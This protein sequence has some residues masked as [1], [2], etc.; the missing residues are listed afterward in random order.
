MRHLFDIYKAP[1]V[2]QLNSGCDVEI[3]TSLPK[4]DQG[5]QESGASAQTCTIG[6]RGSA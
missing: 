3:K 2:L 1:W 5:D 6:F 4:G